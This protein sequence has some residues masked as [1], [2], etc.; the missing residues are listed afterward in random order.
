[1]KRFDRDALANINPRK[2]ATSAM[3][4]IDAL[5]DYLPHEQVAGLCAVFSLLADRYGVRL[6]DAMEVVNNVMTFA[7][8]RRP[9]FKAVEQYMR[10]EW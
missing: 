2:A 1:M 6:P 8:G 10:E 5:Q 9:E 3:S 7:D 4:V